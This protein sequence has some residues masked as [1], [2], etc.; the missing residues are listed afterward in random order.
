[1][2]DQVLATFY[3]RNI[4]TLNKF[5]ARSGLRQSLPPRKYCGLLDVGCDRVLSERRHA[6]V[7]LEVA[8][9]TFESAVRFARAELGL[10]VRHGERLMQSS[11]V[12]TSFIHVSNVLSHP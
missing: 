4:S 3:W 5:E 2:P 10:D 11:R 1:M 7:G 9:W 8:A 6:T 12:D